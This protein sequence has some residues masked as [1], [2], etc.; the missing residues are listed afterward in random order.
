MTLFDECKEALLVDFNIVIGSEERKAI[1]MLYNYPVAAG[2]VLWKEIKYSDYD[3]LYGVLNANL[4]KNHDVFVLADDADIPLFR[5]NIKLIAENVYDVTALSPK[6]FIYNDEIII[7]PLFPSES[8]RVGLR[9]D[10]LC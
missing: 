2:G 7:H 5:T 8:F 9:S 10:N 3:D 1:D 6:L 4:V